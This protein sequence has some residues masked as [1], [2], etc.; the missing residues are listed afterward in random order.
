M[1]A[2]AVVF[3]DE[4]PATASLRA[5]VLAGL[6]RT[7]KAI[8]PKFF[9]DRRG[10]HL[11]ER[12]CGLPEYYL[13]RTEIAILTDNAGEIAGLVGPQSVVIELGCG[14]VDKIRL[15][16]DALRPAAYLGI[17]ISRDYLQT[18]T[19]RL[20]LD[21]P[22][23]RV[24]A[25]CADLCGP[26]AQLSVPRGR[27]RVAFYPGSSIGN[28]EPHEAVQFLSRVREL[29]GP[30]GLLLIGVDLKKDPTVL[31]A[32]YNDA[33]GITAEFNLNL[34][35]RL[36]REL[37]ATL[38][39]DGFAHR[40]F[41]NEDQGR[42]EMHLTCRRPQRMRIDGACFDFSSGETIHTENSYKYSVDEFEQLARASGFVPT[43]L[44]TDARE[45]FA[46]FLLWSP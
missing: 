20:A 18:A 14:A 6:A 28:F 39:P 21:Y 24:H 40:A 23:L 16:L 32:A 41:Y 29:V 1:R 3:Q 31:H 34:L 36:R 15:L 8:S 43:K 4:A 10:S 46:V 44:W 45:F 42:I 11:F 19:R 13:T 26:L 33:E 37:N 17:D 35:H 25:A 30:D 27:R 38:D 5:E 7:P 2:K 22:W 9:Y 12:I